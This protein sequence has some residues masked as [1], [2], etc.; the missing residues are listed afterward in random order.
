LTLLTYSVF[1]VLAASIVIVL[2]RGDP[3]NWFFAQFSTFV[4]GAYFPVDLFPAWIQRI[5]DF[6]PMTYAY[7]GMRM[8][9]LTGAGIREVGVDILVLAVFVIVGLPLAAIACNGAV[10]RAKRDGSLGSF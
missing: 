2:K 1:G 3:I 10:T 8:T 9:L 6:L 4:A 7:R 5:A